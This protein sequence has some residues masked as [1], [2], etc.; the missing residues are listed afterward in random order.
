MNSERQKTAPFVLRHWK[1]SKLRKTGTSTTILPLPTAFFL[2]DFFFCIFRL[3]FCKNCKSSEAST[4]ATLITTATNKRYLAAQMKH[5]NMAHPKPTQSQRAE[6]VRNGR[7][8]RCSEDDIVRITKRQSLEYRTFTG[9]TS[10]RF[11]MFNRDIN[12]ARIIQYLG[13]C[14]YEQFVNKNLK[15]SKN[16]A[17]FKGSPEK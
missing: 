13:L 11:R 17:F 3:K 8:D 16:I 4:P 15:T 9:T 7:N 6:R 12:A 5:T 14:R 1:V 2:T 10:Q